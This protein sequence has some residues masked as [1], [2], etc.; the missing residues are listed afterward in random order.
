MVLLANSVLAVNNTITG[1]NPFVYGQCPTDL[2]GFVM[3][4]GMG[5]FI[6]AMLWFC[7]K[8]VRV[9]FLTILIGVGFIIWSTMGLFGCSS[10]FGMMGIA[11]GVGIIAFEFITAVIK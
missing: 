8:M 2:F 4:F 3:Y 7:K 10:I 5:A 6:L 9:P 11:F 1:D